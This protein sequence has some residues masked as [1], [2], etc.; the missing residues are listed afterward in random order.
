MLTPSTVIS[1]SP[2]VLSGEFDAETVMLDL[3]GGVYYGLQDAGTR[4]WQMLASPTTVAAVRDAIL[5]EYDVE[6]RRCEVDLMELLDD[7]IRRGLVRVRRAD[8]AA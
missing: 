8:G 1:A 4:I 3:R 6:P 7:L 5:A 2:D